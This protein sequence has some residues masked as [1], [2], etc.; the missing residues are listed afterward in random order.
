ME[1]N[2]SSSVVLISSLTKLGINRSKSSR[3]YR[4]GNMPQ[5]SKK[6]DITMFFTNKTP[7]PFNRFIIY[8][9]DSVAEP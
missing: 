7:K 8:H 5:N 4:A 6:L 1:Q 2:R 9:L 3:K